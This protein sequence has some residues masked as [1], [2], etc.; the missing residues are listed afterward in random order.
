MKTRHQNISLVFDI[1][2]DGLLLDVSKFWVGWTYCL[3]SKKYEKFLDVNEMIDYLNTATTLIGHNIIGYDI[4]ALNKLGRNK[5]RGD[6]K[7][8]DTLI[9]SRLAYYDADFSFSHS[10]NAYGQRLGFPKGDH[11]DWTKYSPEMDEYCKRDVDVTVKVLQHLRRK[12]GQ[13]LPDTALELEQ[14]VQTII[15]QQHLNGWLFDVKAAQA[16]HVELLDKMDKAERELHEVFKPIKSFVPKK[17]P[18]TAYKKD[19]TKSQALLRQEALGCDTFIIDGQPQWG[20][21]EDLTFNPGSG[22]HIHKFIEHY[23]GKQRWEMTEKGTPRTDAKSLKKM[24]KDKEFATPLLHYQE[25]KKLLGQL[26]EGQGSWL[27]TVCTDKKIHHNVN[28]LGAVTGRATHSSPNLAQVPSPRAFKGAEV[29]KLFIPRN[30]WVSVGCDLSGVELRCLA[31]YMA[32][33]DGG[34]YGKK[35]IE[36]D[37]HTAN[38][39]AAGLPTRDNAKTFI[40]GFLYGAGDAKIGEIVKGTSADGKRLKTQFLAKTKGLEKLVKGV[41]QAAKRGYLIGITGRRLYVRSPHA[42]LNVLLQSL[43]GYISKY[44]MIEAHKKIKEVGIRCNQLGWIHDELQF[45]CHPDDS[46]SLSKIL[47]D[48]AVKAGEV[49]GLRIRIDAEAKIGESWY[50]VH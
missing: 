43:G 2:T 12:T 32:R 20:Y 13:W 44:W 4:P 16:L 27:N 17:Y 22:Q 18:T 33:H 21:Y 31:H 42:A 48:S 9:L 45:E 3:E 30:G 46:E 41:Q 29:R 24:F 25:V 19:G 47:E 37:I 50:D 5:V 38:Q 39:I 28:I 15:V 1:E 36:E 11:S 14:A 40:Y 49:M 23:F 26:A 8:V 10:L 6:V 35:L 34:E 7:I